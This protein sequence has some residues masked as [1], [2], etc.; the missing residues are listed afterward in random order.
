[1]EHEMT[2]M[3]GGI[4]TENVFQLRCTYHKLSIIFQYSLGIQE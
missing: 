2:T 3:H 1:M 4:I